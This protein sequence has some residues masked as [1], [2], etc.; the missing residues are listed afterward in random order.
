[1]GRSGEGRRYVRIGYV[2]RAGTLGVRWAFR[3]VI[4][5]GKSEFTVYF[6]VVVEEKV[7]EEEERRRR[8]RRRQR[9]ARARASATR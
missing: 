6:R 5:V 9:H 8:E 1:M 2:L 3:D 7:D 4:G